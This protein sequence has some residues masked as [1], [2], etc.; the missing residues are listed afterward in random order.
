[1]SRE[2]RDAL[3]RPR[4]SSGQT[5]IVMSTRLRPDHA[6]PLHPE[7]SAIDRVQ[8]LKRTLGA[9]E[10]GDDGEAQVIGKKRWQPSANKEKISSYG[11]SRQ[12]KE[13]CLAKEMVDTTRK[14]EKKK[15]RRRGST[16]PPA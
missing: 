13:G 15:K 8:T 5:V 2:A 9:S 1:M 14:I 11:G 12:K 4:Q 10:I 16:H 7:P 3:R 6:D